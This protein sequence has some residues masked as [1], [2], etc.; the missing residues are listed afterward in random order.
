MTSVMQIFIVRDI[1]LFKVVHVVFLATGPC[2]VTKLF[3]GD[4]PTLFRDWYEPILPRSCY[5]LSIPI[6]PFDFFL[7]PSSST[8]VSW[9]PLPS[10][11][12]RLIRTALCTRFSTLVLVLDRLSKQ[13]SIASGL[14]RSSW[15]ICLAALDLIPRSLSAFSDLHREPVSSAF[16][17]VWSRLFRFPWC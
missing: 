14:H 12:P 8:S 5:V 2:S 16:S 17:P 13:T 9:L 3:G 6:P 1:Q 11:T 10:T 4:V 15:T 7:Y